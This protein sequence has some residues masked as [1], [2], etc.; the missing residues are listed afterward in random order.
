MIEFNPSTKIISETAKGKKRKI[1]HS[2]RCSFQGDDHN[3]NDNN[4]ISNYN[5]TKRNEK[6]MSSPSTIYSNCL[7][8]TDNNCLHS[9]IAFFKNQKYGNRLIRKNSNS[10]LNHKDVHYYNVD[11]DDDDDDDDDEAN[12]DVQNQKQQQ[13]Q[14]HDV[15]IS[16]KNDLQITKDV[17]NIFSSFNNEFED[18]S[19]LNHYIL[20]K[21]QSKF[22]LW[23]WYLITTK[24]NLLLYGIGCKK[25]II[26]NF[27]K[28]Y[29]LNEDVIEFNS[30]IPVIIKHEHH[31]NEYSNHVRHQSYGIKILFKNIFKSILIDK[32]NYHDSDDICNGLNTTAALGSYAKHLTGKSLLHP[33]LI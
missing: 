23:C 28:K 30:N 7:H 31:H 10:I 21:Y 29:L 16:L 32:N 2:K 3:N 27:I 24:H 15:Q 19:N 4:S 5:N 18:K 11:G 33:I 13:Q 8:S 9:T 6:K 20:R 14:Q 26:N 1:G 12:D 22:N 17:N 25:L